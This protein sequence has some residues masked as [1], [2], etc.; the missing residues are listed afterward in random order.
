MKPDG[1]E[2]KR[3]LPGN[4]FPEARRSASAD[5][6]LRAEIRHTE[7]MSIEERI[8]AALSLGKRFKGLQTPTKGK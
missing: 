5:A 4:A 3:G 1:I 2:L 6:S 8:R 7:K